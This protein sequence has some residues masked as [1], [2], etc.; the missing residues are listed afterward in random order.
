MLIRARLAQYMLL[1]VFLYILYGIIYFIREKR[2][3]VDAAAASCISLPA[4]VA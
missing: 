2:L 4:L 1:Y 3:V